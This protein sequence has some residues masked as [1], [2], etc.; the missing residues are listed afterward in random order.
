MGSRCGAQSQRRPAGQGCSGDCVQEARTPEF[1]HDP[2]LTVALSKALHG[3]EPHVP[4]SIQD[5]RRIGAP[6]LGGGC[7]D[8]SVRPGAGKGPL[9]WAFSGD[10]PNVLLQALCFLGASLQIHRILRAPQGP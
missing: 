2:P 5:S 9:C 1:G 3:P 7:S 10:C 6:G 4:M 8:P